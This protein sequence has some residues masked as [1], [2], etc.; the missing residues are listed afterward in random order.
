MCWEAFFGGGDSGEGQQNPS[1]FQQIYSSQQY[2]PYQQITG[3]GS[4]AAST[5]S[6]NFPQLG[7]AGFVPTGGWMG[8]G[9]ANFIPGAQQ[10]LDPTI[11]ANMQR[12]LSHLTT[13]R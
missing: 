2:Q 6:G 5:L 9:N 11:L 3:Q 1:P 4:G 7:S 12:N 10:M 8:S 13:F